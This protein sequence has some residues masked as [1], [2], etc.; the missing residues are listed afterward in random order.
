MTLFFSQRLMKQTKPSGN[1][2]EKKKKTV[3]NKK[4]KKQ[5]K[6]I[7]VSKAQVSNSTIIEFKNVEEICWSWFPPCFFQRLHGVF[8]FISCHMEEVFR[9]LVSFWSKSSVFAVV[10]LPFWGSPVLLG[11]YSYRVSGR[12]TERCT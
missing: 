5:T 9:E 2:G 1:K 10:L 12:V 7:N 3:E 4:V 8:D 11:L 6:K